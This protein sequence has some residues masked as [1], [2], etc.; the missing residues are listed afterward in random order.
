MEIN[1]GSLRGKGNVPLHALECSSVGNN[2]HVTVLHGLGEHSA[3]YLPFAKTLVNAGYNVHLHDHRHHGRS[4]GTRGMIHRFDDLLAD[5]EK[6]INEVTDRYGSTFVFGHSLGSLALIRLLAEKR[7][8]IRGA[9]VTGAALSPGESLN[10]LLVHSAKL[11]GRLMPWLPLQKLD[12]KDLSRDTALITE[13]L[14]DPFWNQQRIY[15]G[16]LEQVLTAIEKA[17][18]KL[19]RIDTPILIMHGT[20]DALTSPDSSKLLFNNVASSD[21]QLILMEGLKHELLNELERRQVMDEIVAWLD[22][23]R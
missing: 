8:N 4:G 23:R 18:K 12:P 1:I 10:S 19:S 9:I 15:A 7:I 6:R 5:T 11:T 2:A 3:R 20:A 21:K 13:H 22:K 14:S 16:T 17:R